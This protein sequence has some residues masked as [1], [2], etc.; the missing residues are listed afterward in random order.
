MRCFD[1]KK[2][3]ALLFVLIF[4]FSLFP[5]Q[6]LAAEGDYYDIL[7]FTAKPSA[8][9]IT[10]E[11]AGN[12]TAAYFL[13]ERSSFS[14]GAGDD[15][16]AIYK[17]A[18]KT[19]LD[20][21]VSDGTYYSYMLTAY[22]AD[23]NMLAMSWAYSNYYKLD[24]LTMSN[25]TMKLNKGVSRK[26]TFSTTPQHYDTLDTPQW[27]SSN[28]KVATVS[29]KGVVKAIAPGSATIT[30]TYYG[31]KATCKITVPKKFDA[32]ISVAA[33]DIS[34]PLD[35][36]KGTDNRF[37]GIITSDYAI[38][39]VTLQ[40]LNSK[41]KKEASYTKKYKNTKEKTYKTVDLKSF[42]G[43]LNF[44]KLK[45]GTKTF[46]VIVKNSKATVT[47]KSSK[48]KV[49]IKKA[50]KDKLRETIIKWA[51]TRIGDPYSQPKRGQGRYTDCSYF[52]QWCY[53]QAGI[54]IPSTSKTQAQYCVKNKKLIAFEKLKNGD[55]IFF[56]NDGS[57]NPKQ[58]YHVALYCDGG[59]IDAGRGGVTERWMYDFA[60]AGR[61]Y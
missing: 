49:G 31:L 38:K 51:R 3:L 36:I 37:G 42:T 9:G 22:S 18:E 45:D 14:W 44:K 43:K 2:A 20:A 34:T 27:R 47:I 39:E 50:K 4:V 30:V 46:K 58:V 33:T 13:L 12:G 48:F 40:V 29:P 57:T 28:T 60:F 24:K 35:M 15:T 1:L 19:F 26:L 61:P 41:N 10:L 55:L 7:S 5:A 11:W 23:G 56:T 52:T 17:G 32:K 54:S 21:A 25:K 16:R 59:I 6:A 53:K 8:K